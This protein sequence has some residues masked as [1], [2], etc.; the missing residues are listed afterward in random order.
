VKALAELVEVSE[1]RL[2]PN[3]NLQSSDSPPRRCAGEV[4]AQVAQVELNQQIAHL[5]FA[6]EID[7]LPVA[8]G[9]ARRPFLPASACSFACASVVV[10]RNDADDDTIGDARSARR[11]A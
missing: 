7:F 6:D 2:A 10:V 5:S 8:G 11:P 9:F 1:S 4:L 3:T